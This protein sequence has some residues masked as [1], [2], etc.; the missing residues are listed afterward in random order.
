MIKP[1]DIEPD[2]WATVTSAEAGH[3]AALRRLIERDR[4]LARCEYWYTPAIHFAVRG[5]HLEAVRVLL[6]A[7]ADPEWH[8]YHRAACSRPCAR[9]GGAIS[10]HDC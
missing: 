3:T 7:D 6:K 2:V 9:T 5:G 1:H 4:R 10:W 8:G